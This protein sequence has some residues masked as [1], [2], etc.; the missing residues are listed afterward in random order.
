MR[1][2]SQPGCIKGEMRDY[3]L[4]GLNWMISL[5]ENGL[6]GILADEMG[7]GKT[8]QAL[9]AIPPD[10]AAMVV[11]DPLVMLE[12]WAD[13]C[14]KWRKD[15]TPTVLKRASDWRW[16]QYGELLITG[17]GRLLHGDEIKVPPNEATVLIGDEIH[18]VK[19]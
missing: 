3:Q 16:P 8:I 14:R 6:N 9:C 2:L 15:L 17:Y 1:L 7:L 13:E 12:V 19:S 11:A 5:H 18:C 10:G 4:E